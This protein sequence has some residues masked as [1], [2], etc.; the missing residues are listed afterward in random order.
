MVV[1]VCVTE[2]LHGL[3]DVCMVVGCIKLVTGAVEEA[4]DCVLEEGDPV[5][6]CWLADEL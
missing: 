1:L 4:W 3:V 2:V 6:D 5:D